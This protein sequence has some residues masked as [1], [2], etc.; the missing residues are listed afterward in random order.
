MALRATALGST[1]GSTS[2]VGTATVTV[3]ASTVVGDVIVVVALVN[4]GSSASFTPP[5]SDGWTS[6]SG[7]DSIGGNLLSQVW[8][9]TAAAGDI[10]AVKTFTSSSAGRL[11]LLCIVDTGLEA[12]L[13]LT[14]GSSATASTSVA[15]TAVTSTA[16]NSDVIEVAAMRSGTTSSPAVTGAPSG[17]TS[18]VNTS[19]GAVSPSF[20][21]AS[22]HLTTPGAAGSYGGSPITVSPSATYTTYT[23]ALAPANVFS[24]SLNVTG[25]GSTSFAATTHMQS[26][27]FPGAG[28]G[29]LS[30]GGKPSTAGALAVTGSGST[31]FGGKPG[32][33]AT[34]AVSGAG[35]LALSGAPRAAGTLSVTGTG[36]LTFAT[37]SGGGTLVVAGVGTVVFGVLPA[38]KGTLAATG[39]GTL[40]LVGKLLGRGTLTVTGSGT[41]SFTGRSITR[42]SWWNGTTWLSIAPQVWGGAA[43]GW[44][45]IPVTISAVGSFA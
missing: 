5:A 24:G 33:V 39:V 36:T 8:T 42:H 44:L 32:G 4:L 14:T 41:L 22:L 40:L 23:I 2:N 12:G 19:T 37:T 1:N 30:L 28:V 21:I 16:A 25:V 31:S 29:T 35:S 45:T 17:F 3:P 34:L 38:M 10:G 15:T 6:Q 13:V 26:G 7:P 20:A 9:K 18:D 43:L 27:A 11:Q